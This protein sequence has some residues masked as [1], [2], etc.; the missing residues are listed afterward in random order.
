MSSGP[1]KVLDMFVTSTTTCL[2]TAFCSQHLGAQQVIEDASGDVRAV[3]TRTERLELQSI[4]G[5]MASKGWD[6]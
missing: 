1:M 5:T 6:L 2:G 4:I 3:V